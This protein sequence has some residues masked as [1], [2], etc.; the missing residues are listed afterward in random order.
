MAINGD[1]PWFDDEPVALEFCNAPVTC[2]IREECLLFALVNNCKEG[3]FGGTSEID[4]KA[5]RK[6]WPLKSGRVP[7]PEWRWFDP[8]VPASWYDPAILRA[9]LDGEDEDDDDA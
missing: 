8:G 3:V 7:R 1:D 2:P 6:R 4:R 9:E 5:I